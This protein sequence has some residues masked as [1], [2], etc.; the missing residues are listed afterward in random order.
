MT[1]RFEFINVI[2][3]W[4]YCGVKIKSLSID[5]DV[6]TTDIVLFSLILFFNLF[7]TT[8]LYQKLKKTEE[9]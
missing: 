4:F 1:I 2:L 7:Y 9:K 6:G 8:K 3:W 5:T